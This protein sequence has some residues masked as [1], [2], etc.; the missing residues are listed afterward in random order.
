[1]V[2]SFVLWV[3]W[4]FELLL[5]SKYIPC[6]YFWVGLPYSGWYFLGPSICLGIS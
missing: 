4:A 6:M 5:I 1:L 2:N 3:F